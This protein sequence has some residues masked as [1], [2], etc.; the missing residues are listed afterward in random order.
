MKQKVVKRGLKPNKAKVMAIAGAESHK[1]K[2]RLSIKSQDFRA[3]SLENLTA[4]RQEV[5]EA[6][7]RL[8]ESQK[9]SEG[10]LSAHDF[11]EEVDL[12][13]REIS[14][15][16]HYRLLERKNK[17]LKK[18]ETLIRKIAEDEEFGRCEECGKRIPEE[19]LLIVP[20][21]T[22]CVPCQREMEKWDSRV[23]LA[24]MTHSSSGRKK[25]P[26]WGP[27]QDSDDEVKISLKTD[28]DYLSFVDLGDT[29]PGETEGENNGK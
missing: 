22:R 12:A 4:K 10:L 26:G 2:R 29:E 20:E 16:T 25:E 19:R 14:A 11:R 28:M 17:E 15:Q 18:I 27:N 5:E 21:A 13:E 23:A 7:R 6:L 8:T 9:A 3:R 24:E 1:K